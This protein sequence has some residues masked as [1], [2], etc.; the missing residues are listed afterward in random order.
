MHLET[1][2]VLTMKRLWLP[3]VLILFIAVLFVFFVDL[4]AVAGQLRQARWPTLAAATV[5]LLAGLVV[6][7]VRWRYLLGNKPGLPA[8]FHAGNIGHLGNML[9]PIRAGEPARILVLGRQPTVTTA[10]VASSVVVERI[11]EQL[12]RLVGL[13]GAILFGVGLEFSPTTAAGTLLLLAV[14]LGGLFWLVNRRALVL[15]VAPAWLARLPRLSEERARAVLAGLLDGLAAA[16]SPGRLAAAL[17]LSLVSWFCYVAFHY[18]VMVALG[19]NQTAGERLALSFAALALTPPSAPAMPGIFHGSLVG[20]L[21]VIGFDETLLT[22]YAVVLHALEM[23]LVLLLGAWGLSQS[24]VS[25]QD[26][27]SVARKKEIGD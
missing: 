18:L 25:L 10:E 13:G 2:G 4:E 24:P 27:L 17:L 19:A 21:V 14:A 16:G 23:G 20:P 22:A 8:V 12:A 7:A 1:C 3:L 6:Y 5:V 15:A 11:F 9:T 26:I